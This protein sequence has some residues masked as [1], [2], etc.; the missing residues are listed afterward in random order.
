MGVRVER[1]VPRKSVMMVR[2][3]RENSG[4]WNMFQTSPSQ[5]VSEMKTKG[6]PSPWTS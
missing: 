2:W 3:S 6:G 1:P 5:A 4:T